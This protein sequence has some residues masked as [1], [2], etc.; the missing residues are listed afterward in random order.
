[1]SVCRFITASDTLAAAAAAAADDEGSLTQPL[2]PQSQSA[3]DAAAGEQAPLLLQPKEAAGARAEAGRWVEAVLLFL[4][5]F[6]K[7]N[8][9]A[10][11]D[12]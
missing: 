3:S 10:V 9:G 11:I 5:F 12:W 2:L 7:D 1:M 8:A 4:F 6:S